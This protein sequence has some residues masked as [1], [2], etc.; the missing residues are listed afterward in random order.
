[1]CEGKLLLDDMHGAIL[2]DGCQESVVFG[3]E[4]G[5]KEAADADSLPEEIFLELD[6]ILGS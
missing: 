6:T 4:L 5:S 1:M 3:M 2:V